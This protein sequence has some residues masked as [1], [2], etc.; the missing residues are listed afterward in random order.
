MLAATIDFQFKVQAVTFVKGR[1]ACTLNSADM[2]ECIGLT[3]VTLDE[4]KALHGVEELHRAASAFAGQLALRTTAITTT[5][6][7]KA[8]TITTEAASAGFARFTRTIHDWKGLTFDLQISGGNLAAA[9]DQGETKL[10]TFG[11]AGQACLLNGADVDEHVFRAIVTDD[12]AKALLAVEELYD[13]SAFANNLGWHA[14]AATA[15]AE[16]ATTA[17]AKA[18]TAAAAET[19]AAAT[20]AEAITAAAEAAAITTAETTTI[21]KTTAEAATIA[22]AV[23]I[24]VAETV[25]LV[26]AAPAAATSIKTHAL[27]VTF[28]SPKTK[29]DKHAG[30]N[31]MQNP[32][33][34]CGF[35]ESLYQFFRAARMILARLPPHS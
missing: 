11:Q 29:S 4:A 31:D 16:A 25:A 10:L 9:I 17:A 24:V 20:A 15:A 1:H 12:E 26:L 5:V 18:A 33:Q 6:A 21:S 30:R 35:R 28:A 7:A 3:I 27:L 2:H 13:A 23:K 22:A 32:P 14:A 19:T 34:G 8:A